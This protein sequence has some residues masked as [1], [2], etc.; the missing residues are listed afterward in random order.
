[1]DNEARYQPACTASTPHCEDTMP[2]IRKENDLMAFTA[3]RGDAKSLLAFDLKTDAAR[4]GLG[5]F[6]I[7]VHPP[8]GAD[9]YYIDNNLRLAESPAHAQVAGETPF[10]S[11][12]APIHKFRWVHVPGLVHQGGQPAFGT[13]TYVVTPRY[14]TDAGALTPLDPNASASLDID[15]G[16]FVSGALTLGFTRGY[17][18][19]QAFVRHFGDQV[20]IRPGNT[21]LVFDTSATAGSNGA[22]QSYT[23]A[24]EYDWLGF[25]ARR[26]I[27]DLLDKVVADPTLKMDVFAYDLDEPD[28]VSALLTLAEQHRVRIVLDSAALH[29]GTAAA[30]SP[31]DTFTQEFISRAGGD[32][33]IK[34][35]KFGRYAHDKV[36]I[37]SDATGPRTV[38]TGSTNFSVSGM[39]VNANHVLVFEDRDVAGIYSGVFNEAW[40]TDVK[41]APF[42]QSRWGTDPFPW[43]GAGT[44]LPA[45][46]ATFSPHAAAVADSILQGLVTRIKAE[47]DVASPKIGSVFFAVMGLTGPG[48]NPVYDALNTLHANQAIFSF[49]ISDSPKSVSLYGVGEQ[50]GVLVTGK[51]GATMLPPPFNQVPNIAFHE[52][53]HKFVVCGFNGDD[54]VVYCGSS[55]LAEGGEQQNGD[56]LLAIRDADVAT[57][58]VIEASSLVDHYNFLDKL[59]TKTKATGKAAA[60][61]APVATAD[62]QSAAAA[63]GWFLSTTDGW[64]NK[65]FDPTDLHFKDRTL[66]GA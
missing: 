5:G 56:N 16:P 26:A 18:Q 34:R 62:K 15:V 46:T 41:Q 30:P 36:F 29:T 51:P 12:N 32:N 42:A 11:V 1:M 50:G 54:P 6:T 48:Q 19:S 10:S 53:H 22:G 23:Y 9:P 14:F 43:G 38:L 20:H 61:V 28:V 39:Y 31:E 59:A 65:Y 27:F 52:I 58:F 17:V 4:K 13:Y 66:F 55:N 25:T 49:G 44:N 63:A 33:A 8:G 47:G 37:V 35:R 45:T 21:D 3:Y 7:E 64:T 40:D 24:A 60:A 2:N 57:A